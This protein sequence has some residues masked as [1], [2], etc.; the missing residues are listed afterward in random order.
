M[1]LLLPEPGPR[2]RR[3]RE[4][5]VGPIMLRLGVGFGF[6]LGATLLLAAAAAQAHFVLVRPESWMSQ[7]ASGNPQKLGPCGDEGGGTATGKVT[8]FQAGQTITVTIDETVFHP[9]HYRIALA[10]ESRS[11]LPPEPAVTP[12]TTPCGSAAID[13]SPSFPVLADG[14]LQHTTPFAGAQSLQVTLPAN[15]DCSKCTLQVLEFMGSHGLN[16]PGGC[17]YHHCADISIQAAPVGAGGSQP[18]SDAGAAAARGGEAGLGG[19]GGT[20]WAGAGKANSAGGATAKGGGAANGVGTGGIS[21]GGQATDE[22][23]PSTGI[24][25]FGIPTRGT[26]TAFGGVLALC[27]LMAG[28]RMRGHRLRDRRTSG[29]SPGHLIG[30][31]ARCFTGSSSAH[32]CRARS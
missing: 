8:A 29:R 25:A 16:V 20:P 17:F 2:L 6:A 15:V 31:D 4:T 24:C 5:R 9:G 7:D 21:A 18:G 27:A 22:G 12:D 26:R 1:E 30:L 11:D 13:P 19:S 3:L 28:Y 10:L 23:R 14:V 32:T